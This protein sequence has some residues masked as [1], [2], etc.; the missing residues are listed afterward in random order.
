MGLLIINDVLRPR[1]YA[2]LPQFTGNCRKVE[3]HCG[4]G[5]WNLNP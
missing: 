1:P 3:V 4:K 2:P 5:K